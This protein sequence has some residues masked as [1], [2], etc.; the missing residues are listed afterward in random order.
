MP[1]RRGIEGK[2][3]YAADFDPTKI[4][5]SQ[6]RVVT[7][8][9]VVF[10]SFDKEVEPIDVDVGTPQKVFGVLRR[11]ACGK[12]RRPHGPGNAS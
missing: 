4:T 8:N 1:F 7:Y 9:G 6:L 2:G 12:L 11:D 3:G 10:A 5:L